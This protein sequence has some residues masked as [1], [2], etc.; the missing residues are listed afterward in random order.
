MNVSTAVLCTVLIRRSIRYAVF[1][2]MPR[3][4]FCLDERSCLVTDCGRER[5][6]SDYFC[7]RHMDKAKRVSWKVLLMGLIIMFLLLIV[8]SIDKDKI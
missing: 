4:R 7:S 2:V 6:S 1:F 5:M 3:W 8:V